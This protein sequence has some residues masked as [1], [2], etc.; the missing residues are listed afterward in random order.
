VPYTSG[1]RRYDLLLRLHSVTIC[2]DPFMRQFLKMDATVSQIPLPGSTKVSQF[3]ER[4]AALSQISVLGS[5][6]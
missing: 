6:L 5:A 1:K 4:D 3:I 2:K